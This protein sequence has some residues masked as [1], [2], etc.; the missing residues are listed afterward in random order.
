M[1]SCDLKGSFYNVIWSKSLTI[2]CRL[3]IHR[4]EV[5]LSHQNFWPIFL[6]PF[7]QV[8]DRIVLFLYLLK[9]RMVIK[10][11]LTDGKLEET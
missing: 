1:L 10:L 9:V 5:V 4:R 7:C 6:F 8:Y 11:V 2:T 3:Y